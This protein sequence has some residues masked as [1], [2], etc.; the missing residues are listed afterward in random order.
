MEIKKSENVQIRPSEIVTLTDMG[1]LVEV[2]HMKK[3]NTQQNIKKLSKSHYVELSSGEIKE[4]NRSNNR[5]DNLNSLRQTFKKMRYLINNN[6]TGGSNELFLTLTY[7]HHVV[8]HKR[9]GKDWDRF[10][11]RLKRRFEGQ[12]TVEYMRMLEPQAS[13][14]YHLHVLLRFDGLDH[15]F[16]PK[17][18]LANMWGLGFIDVR[19]HSDVDNIG[20]Y[21]TAYMTDIVLPD[22]DKRE[23][24]KEVM[25]DGKKKSVLK[26]ARLGFYD[27]GAN[28][29]TKSRGIV[30]PD[31]T[32]MTY[33]KAQKKVG[34]AKPHFARKIDIDIDG[35]TNSISYEQYNLKRK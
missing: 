22:G 11:K 32:R 13:G 16:I 3:V 18:D 28:I 4:F 12:A 2:Q 29:F 23:G 8:C 5:G 6:F 30:Y 34:S 24:A 7:A 15:V 10:L 1:H 33:E 14:R 35:F 17:D 19:R 21:L 27:T 25:I 9:V 26:G 20:A 31:R